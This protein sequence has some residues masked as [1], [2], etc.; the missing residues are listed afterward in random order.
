MIQSSHR[1]LLGMILLALTSCAPGQSREPAQGTSESAGGAVFSPVAAETKP[2]ADQ[3]LLAPRYI[4]GQSDYIEFK[5]DVTQ[6][7]SERGSPDVTA[8]LKRLYGM[9]RRVESVSKDGVTLTLTLDRAMHEKWSQYLRRWYDSDRLDNTDELPILSRA[10]NVVLRRVFQFQLNKRLE[11][12]DVQIPDDID[13]ALIET[14]D[15]FFAPEV[16]RDFSAQRLKINWVL[17]PAALYA[18][19]PVKVGDTWTNTV[20]DQLP[21]QGPARMLFECKLEKLEGEPGKRLATVSFKGAL[22]LTGDLNK[23]DR[24]ARSYQSEWDGVATFDEARR[25]FTRRIQQTRTRLMFA[26]KSANPKTPPPDQLLYVKVDQSYRVTTLD[27]RLAEQ[28][29]LAAASQPKPASQPAG[30]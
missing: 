12:V 29:A 13:K 23:L 30:D 14:Q 11:V 24:Y 19:K 28:K 25:E 21:L 16:Q 18:N 9:I 20:E 8:G 17:M 15:G 4:A 1:P 2:A 5:Q 7:Q 6:T 26:G 3:I 22:Q 10:L 27:E